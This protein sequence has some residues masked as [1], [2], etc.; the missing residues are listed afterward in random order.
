MPN[1]KVQNPNEEKQESL[2]FGSLDL[3]WHLDFDIRASTVIW[4]LTFGFVQYDARVPG[5]EA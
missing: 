4:I 5:A 2:A 3:S 1:Y